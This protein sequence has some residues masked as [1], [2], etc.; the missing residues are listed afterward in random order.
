M[1]TYVHEKNM[2]SIWVPY[3]SE[4]PFVGPEN[5]YLKSTLGGYKFIY[6]NISWYVCILGGGQQRPT[7]NLMFPLS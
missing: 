2:L 1:K 4:C 6:I 7:G 3:M 5:E